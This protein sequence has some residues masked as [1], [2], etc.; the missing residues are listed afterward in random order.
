[1]VVGGHSEMN[2]TAY[3]LSPR[4][5]YSTSD[6]CCGVKNLVHCDERQNGRDERDDL[7]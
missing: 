5:E 3:L 7:C 6:G 4:A 2:T 1:M